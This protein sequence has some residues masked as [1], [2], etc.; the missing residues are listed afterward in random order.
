M[1]LRD[2][3]AKELSLVQ[4][5]A[6]CLFALGT[7]ETAIDSCALDITAKLQNHNP[8]VLCVLNGGVPYTAALLKRLKFP[9][10]LDYIHA[11]R[12][13]H[14]TVGGGIEFIAYPKTQ[15]AGRTVLLADDIFDEG[16]T[17]AAIV[18]HCLRDGAAAVYT[19]VLV[20]KQHDRKALLPNGQQAADFSALSVEDKYVFGWGMDYKGYLRNLDGIYA[21]RAK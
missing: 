1:Q 19:T 14:N 7:I 9:L 11:T 10:Q 16:Q 6:E 8:V 12:Y 5:E 4:E 13:G 21:V 3:F 20:D 18:Q 17:F 2:E 15:L